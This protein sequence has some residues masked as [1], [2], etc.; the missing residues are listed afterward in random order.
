[1]VSL[2]YLSNVWRTLEMSLTNCKINFIQTWSANCFL[3]TGTLANQVPIFTITAT[4]L[5]VLVVIL[6]T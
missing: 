4:K 3:V 1:M 5:Y 6:S 2:K